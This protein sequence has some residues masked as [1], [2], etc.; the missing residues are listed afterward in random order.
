[1]S[2]GTTGS[3]LPGPEPF[4]VV[5]WRAHLIRFM[6]DPVAYMGAL[7]R[8]YGDIAG[9]V[10]GSTQ[11]FF[12]FGPA[13]NE[14]LLRHTAL[15]HREGFTVEGPADSALHRLGVGLFSMNGERHKQQRR[16]L[17]P[18][19]QQKRIESYRDA[20]AAITALTIDGWQAEEQ[21]DMWQEML[22]LTQRITARTLF[23]LDTPQ[24]DSLGAQ[25]EEWLRLNAHPLMML[26]LHAPG[27]PYHRLLMCSQRL[28]QHLVAIAWQRSAMPSGDL[29]AL[30][31]LVQ[32]HDT[33][34]G[35]M[36]THE[37]VG[38][39][40]TLF[41]G[42]YE[43]AH[44][45][46]TW[47]LFL[48]SQ[49]PAIAAD[50]A[51]ELHG[52]LHGAAPTVE[53]LARLPLLDRVIKESLRLLPPVVYSSCVSTAPFGMGPYEFPAGATI[54]FSQYITHHMPDLYEQPRRF[55]PQRWLNST[56]SPYAYFPFDAGSR[57][58]IG[59]HIAT[60]IFKV[61]LAMIVQRY[62]LVVPAGTT[63]D[64]HLGITLA[65]KRGLPMLILPR[66]RRFRAY[67]VRGNIHEMVDLRRR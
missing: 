13:Y 63:I 39:M 54:W 35:A 15:F 62:R 48:L 42:G 38:H 36:T 1:M 67:D 12:A 55:Q 20:M 7:H 23:G 29:D 26:P 24:A 2:N 46:L 8:A 50:L 41:I 11:R 10:A 21:R 17:M 45:A 66:D 16:L 37:L 40:S 22:H 31:L 57:A 44:N 51:D 47:M 27:T 33:G 19:F 18:A 60:M 3:A 5:A 43:A 32:A 28:E 9:L 34:N 52:V 61:A 58:C 53:Q 14:Q 59:V 6:R 25:I 49:H 65:P 4:P 64:R 30:G 56:P